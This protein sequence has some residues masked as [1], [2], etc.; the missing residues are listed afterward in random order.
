MDENTGTSMDDDIGHNHADK[1]F[2]NG[3]GRDRCRKY[4][5][6]HGNR[7]GVVDAEDYRR[8]GCFC[9]GSS[10]S[11][12]NRYFNE[13]RNFL[14]AQIGDFEFSFVSVLRS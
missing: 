7:V 10:D 12:S 6:T 11:K 8:S 5:W 1:N 9:I 13:I 14:N 4:H 2:S 3:H